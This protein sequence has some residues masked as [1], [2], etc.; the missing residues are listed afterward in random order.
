[1][2]RPDDPVTRPDDPV[3]LPDDLVAA[4]D[5]AV[6]AELAAGGRVLL[7]ATRGR[8][9]G[10]VRVAAIGFVPEP[11]GSLL[12]AANSP[13]TDWARNLQADPS[14]RIAYADLD[15]ACVAEPLDG[16]AASRAVTALILRYGTPAEG[17]GGGPAFRLRP[18][19]TDAD[20]PA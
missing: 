12:V 5:D 4:T 14:C 15:R 8:R 11:D 2:T 20:G 3:T 6:G 17:L 16:A 1:M 13:D 19:P 9:S 7:V 18:V 10:R